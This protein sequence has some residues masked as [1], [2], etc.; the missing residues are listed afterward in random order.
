MAATRGLLK[1]L[2]EEQSG[3]CH[4]CGRLM[5]ETP[6][7]RMATLDHFRPRSKGGGHERHNLVAACFRCNQWKGDEDGETYIARIRR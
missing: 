4:Y 5:T 1:R 2:C 7:G 6:G 3:H